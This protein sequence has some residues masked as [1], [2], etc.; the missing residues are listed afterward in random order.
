MKLFYAAALIPLILA[1]CDKKPEFKAENASVAEVASAANSMI[2]MEPGK[3]RTEVSVDSVEIANAPAQ[4]AD[5][6]KRQLSATGKQT[7]ESCV[8]KEQAER[9]PEDLLGGKGMK[10]CRYDSFAIKGGKLDAQMTCQGGPAGP[11]SKIQSKITGDFGSK[12]YDLVS[13]TSA[14]IQDQSI[15][16]KTKIKG[17]RIGD[18]T[19]AA[20]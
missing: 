9:P 15:T 11:A 18:C 19:P 16:T 17:A 6:M 2:R 12:S 1:G 7:A 14:H 8:T 5:A 3:W 4:V 10:S 20:S 13:E